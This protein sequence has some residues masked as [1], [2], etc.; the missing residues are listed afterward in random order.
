MD[1]IYLTLS[2]RTGITL[3]RAIPIFTRRRLPLSILTNK[4]SSHRDLKP[5]NIIVSMMK[6]AR[7]RPHRG[8]WNCKNTFP[9]SGGDLTQTGEV[10][11]V[12][13]I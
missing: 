11:V 2:K 5:S 9:R 12:Q 4:E 13:C 7:G 1:P 6:T 8:F 10:F 3:Y